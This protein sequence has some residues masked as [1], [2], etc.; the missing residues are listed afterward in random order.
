MRHSAILLC[1]AAALLAQP[2]RADSV[3]Q[4]NAGSREAL[5]ALRGHVQGTDGLLK[6]AAG[7]LVFPD[8]VK[9]GFGVG[10]EFGEGVLLVDGEPKAYYATSG[11]PFGMKLGQQIKSEVIVFRSEEAL[12]SFRNTR[13]WKVGAHAKVA[14]FTG[15]RDA[16][17][18]AREIAEPM[19]SFIFT[20]E[21]ML[22]GLTLDGAKITRLAR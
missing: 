17:Y 8:V 4:I 1:L 20:R 15:A 14:T 22:P 18:K 5:A 9:L 7:V 12:A 2:L 6:K 19:V 11:A 21:A 16:V 10:G 3:E 13:G